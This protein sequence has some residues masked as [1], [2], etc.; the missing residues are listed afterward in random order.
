MAKGSDM[1]GKITGVIIVASGL[2]LGAPAGHA[3]EPETLKSIISSQIEAFRIDDGVTAF[4]FASLKIRSI[5]QSPERFMEMVRRQYAPVYRPENFRFGPTSLETA[6][7]PVQI[8]DIVDQQGS[9]WRAT[10]TFEQH[11]DGSWRIAG[12]RLEKLPGSS[13]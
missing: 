1:L 4:G 6:G 11:P 13:V 12:V 7:R 8:V 10:Y 3:Q 5:F 9:A 2:L